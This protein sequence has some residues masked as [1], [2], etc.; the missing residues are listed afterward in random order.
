MEAE[1]AKRSDANGGLLFSKAEIEEFNQIASDCGQP[2]WNVE[3]L[4]VAS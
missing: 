4:K 3:N 1:A 2:T